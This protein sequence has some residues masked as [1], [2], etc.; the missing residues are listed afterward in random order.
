MIRN[1]LL[2]LLAALP[3]C[4]LAQGAST[5]EPTDLA[6]MNSTPTPPAAAP[7]AVYFTHDISPAGLE[8]AYRALGRPLEGR[9]VAV[10]IST[11]EAGTTH[12]LKPE[13]IGP[14]VRS[15]QGDIVECNTAYGGS[16]Q[17]TPKHRQTIE[18]HGFN[19]IR[20]KTFV[21][22]KAKY[23]YAASGCDHDAEA[24]ADKDHIVAYAQKIKAAGMA[25]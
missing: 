22:P 9:K 12:Y 16:R 5:N 10:K 14:L 21:S 25:F 17:E 18:D 11:G 3:L 2:A 23:G 8:K 6:T 4:G 15:L 24:Y 19:A 13:L 7:A 20:L 1:D